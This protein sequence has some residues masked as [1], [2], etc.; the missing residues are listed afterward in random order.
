MPRH[1]HAF[2]LIELV[3]AIALGMMV[4][5]VAFAGFRVAAVTVQKANRLAVENS[6]IRYGLGRAMEDVDF[7]VGWDD[8]DRPAD[9]QRL[10]ASTAAATVGCDDP[11]AGTLGLP[12]APMATVFPPHRAP[13]SATSSELDRGW[14]PDNHW[15]AAD[16]R[17]WYHGQIMVR[18]QNNHVL[19]STYGCYS[20]FTNLDTAV[21]ARSASLASFTSSA[22]DA[23]WNTYGTGLAPLHTWRDNQV[24]G[25]TQALGFYGMADYLPNNTVYWALGATSGQNGD[26]AECQP[27]MLDSWGTWQTGQPW[28]LS[29]FTGI[30]AAKPFTRSHLLDTAA[31]Q[32][33][34]AGPGGA[35]VSWPAKGL[36][37]EN[38]RYQQVGARGELTVAQ[39]LYTQGL[40]TSDL[41]SER[42]AT[43]ND[44]RLQVFRSG[45]RGRMG[46][47]VSLAWFDPQ[48]GREQGLTFDVPGTTLRGARQQRNKDG[49]AKWDNVPLGSSGPQ[50]RAWHAADF[51]PAWYLRTNANAT[52]FALPGYDPAAYRTL[53]TTP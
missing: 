50:H 24:Y 31:L 52:S 36:F 2:T 46:A 22:S 33:I 27:R 35:A 34:S 38:F 20:L 26:D 4:V 19:T 42:P 40:V 53:D 49:W 32:M 18:R 11:R 15:S 13:G 8:P 39:T 16:P 5:L 41:L 30:G 37:E 28:R 14:D 25:L 6:L 43:W 23:Q 7:W 3:I 21:T 29:P 10:R 1:R 48:T 47:V 45:M 9:G 12:F 17:T 44:L 51:S